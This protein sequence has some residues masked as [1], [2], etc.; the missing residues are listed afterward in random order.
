MGRVLHTRISEN[1]A[2]DIRRVA[3]DLRVPVSNLVRNVLEDVFTAVE[4]VAEN[5]GEMVDDVIEEVDCASSRLRRR[6]W[7]GSR[8]GQEDDADSP[9]PDR[10]SPDPSAFP[11]V[12]G[13]QPLIV[14]APRACAGCGRELARG[15]RAFVGLRESGPSGVWLCRDCALAVS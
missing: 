13:W 10:Q 3:E 8:R 7:A 6:S 11:E 14:Q 12:V 2:E 4:S 5:L 9:E 15:E 1:L